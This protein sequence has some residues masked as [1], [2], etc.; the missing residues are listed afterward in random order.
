MQKLLE[1]MLRGSV[2]QV[3]K[4]HLNFKEVIQIPR[5]WSGS[6]KEGKI[7]EGLD[8]SE[9]YF[10]HKGYNAQDGYFETFSMSCIT[11]CSSAGMSIG[12]HFSEPNHTNSSAVDGCYR[13]SY[14]PRHGICL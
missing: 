7:V 10:P 14:L 12:N 4:M 2:S 8:I 11:I 9:V 6:Q 5:A 1:R 3:E 13:M